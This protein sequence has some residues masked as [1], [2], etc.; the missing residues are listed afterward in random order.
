MDQ[1]ESGFFLAQIS[2][3]LFL[4]SMSSEVQAALCS[5]VWASVRP[6][7][8]SRKTGAVCAKRPGRSWGCREAQGLGEGQSESKRVLVSLL[9]MGFFRRFSPCLI[10]QSPP[11]FPSL[12]LGGVRAAD[13]V[14]SVEALVKRTGLRRKRLWVKNRYRTLVSGETLNSPG[15]LILTH[16]HKTTFFGFALPAVGRGERVRRWVVH[17]GSRVRNFWNCLVAVCVSHD[18]LVVPLYAFDPPRSEFW[19][20][21]EWFML[22]FWN[23]DFFASL[24][25]GFYDEGRLIMSWKRIAVNYAKTWMFFDLSLISMDW[26]FRILDWAHQAPGNWSKS[27][28]MLR[29]LRLLRM[30]R[31]I[32]LRKINEVTQELFHTQ[33][34]RDTLRPFKTGIGGGGDPPLPPPYGGGPETCRGCLLKRS[35]KSQWASFLRLPACTTGCS[36]ALPLCWSRTT[37]WHALGLP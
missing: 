6:R 24:C 12:F 4:V 1:C 28:R 18:L 17:P 20:F 34:G 36:A 35:E 32:K 5:G 14:T 19:E 31:W 21:L 3:D 15:G 10:L 8:P 2:Q 25:T 7:L 22:L 33:A 26:S 29:F 37:C 30:L 23:L 16:T 13:T 11:R 27:L 9:L